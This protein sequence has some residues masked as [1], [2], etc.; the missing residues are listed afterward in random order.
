[1]ATDDGSPTV[2]HTSAT[3]VAAA[4]FAMLAV[5]TALILARTGLTS[6]ESLPPLLLLATHMTYVAK[7]GATTRKDTYVWL[8]D[9][10][11]V[12][13]AAYFCLVIIWPFPIH[14]YDGLAILALLLTSNDVTA[15]NVLLALYYSISAAAHAGHGEALQAV[16]RTLLGA[17]GGLAL[18]AQTA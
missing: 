9:L 4:A 1:M 16:G 5:A 12:L 18:H 3:W 11:R 13:R 6:W 17:V 7:Y 14:W 8:N 15:G 10:A 2:K